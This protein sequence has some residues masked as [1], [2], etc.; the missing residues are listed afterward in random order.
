MIAAGGGH[1]AVVERLLANAASVNDAGKVACL[2][3]LCPWPTRATTTNMP[4]HIQHTWLAKHTLPSSNILPQI[5]SSSI[6]DHTR[7]HNALTH[8]HTF[9][10]CVSEYPAYYF[11]T[12]TWFRHSL[13]LA[14]ATLCPVHLHRRCLPCN[15]AGCLHGATAS[16][17]LASLPLHLCEGGPVCGSCCSVCVCE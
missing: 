5:K 12:R 15:E 13:L 2:S 14:R 8:K 7:A 4:V 6:N 3:P 17:A 9:R 1:D 10:M 11:H 16:L